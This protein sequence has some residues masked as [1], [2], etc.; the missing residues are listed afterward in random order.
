MAFLL[1]DRWIK[2]FVVRDGLLIV[3]HDAGEVR[4]PV[5]EISSHKHISYA[6]V[7]IRLFSGQRYDLSLIRFRSGEIDDLMKTLRKIERTNRVRV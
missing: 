4:L 5:K 7:V 2:H 1:W 6:Q 3:R